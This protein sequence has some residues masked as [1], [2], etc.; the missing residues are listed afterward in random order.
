MF[1]WSHFDEA[2]SC[3]FYPW[4]IYIYQ[5]R[6]QTRQRDKKEARQ[7]ISNAALQSTNALATIQDVD[8]RLITE[9]DF[10]AVRPKI[11]KNAQTSA[12]KDIKWSKSDHQDPQD[13]GDDE[14]LEIAVAISRA[15]AEEN[16]NK[17]IEP[18][19]MK[20]LL[21]NAQFVS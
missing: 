10:Q 13:D 21:P 14:E 2:F 3:I 15:D 11:R 8:Q 9:V 7:I 6:S 4:I 20:G 5:L 18:D 17:R 19:E 1:L 16:K 12:K